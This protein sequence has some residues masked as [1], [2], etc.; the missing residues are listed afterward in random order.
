MTQQPENEFPTLGLNAPD[1]NRPALNGTP[2]NDQDLSD[3]ECAEFQS[4]MAERIGAGED[5]YA[6]DH[7]ATCPRC[8]ALLR[9]L[10]YM[11]ESIRTAFQDQEPDLEPGDK[12]WD[13]ILAKLNENEA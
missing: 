8:P 7:M 3:Q 12:V 4:R 1:L 2:L 11:A 13:N 5:L 10:E 9:D 6:Y